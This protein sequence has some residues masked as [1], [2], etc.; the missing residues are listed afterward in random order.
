MEERKEGGGRSHLTHTRTKASGGSVWAGAGRALP[1]T[2]FWQAA[3]CS[4]QKH[5]LLHEEKAPI[6]S[7][8]ASS[9]DGEEDRNRTSPVKQLSSLPCS[10]VPMVNS[11]PS[12]H[13]GYSNNIVP[14][15]YIFIT[16]EKEGKGKEREEQDSD[17]T[18]TDSEEKEGR[19]ENLIVK[20]EKNGRK[21]PP[22]TL[23]IILIIIPP[24]EGEAE[25]GWDGWFLSIFLCTALFLMILHSIFHFSIN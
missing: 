9:S 12:S 16:Q 1:H 22:S 5:M 20:E 11:M 24:E 25:T 10:S 8:M 13:R 6:S 21:N 15:I 4:S 2:P 7:D 19:K 3:L 14:H 17:K 18:V 23:S